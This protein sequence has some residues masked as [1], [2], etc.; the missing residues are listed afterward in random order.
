MR[1]LAPT[2]IGMAV[3]AGIAPS[4]AAN[5]I[6]VRIENLRNM[7]G[8]VHLCLTAD[9]VAF[10]D[11]DKDPNA[12]RQT[13]AARQASLVRFEDVTPGA[14]ALALFHDENGNQKLDTFLGIPREGYGFSQ[15]PT[16]RFGPPSFAQARFNVGKG[17]A[18]L[19][20]RMQYL[21]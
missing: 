20:V 17:I 9:A 14:H 10:P 1:L 21:I 12:L 16:V 7:R 11:C 4:A 3:A 13:V 6:E 18:R 8:V 19:T 5:V 15:N 2:S